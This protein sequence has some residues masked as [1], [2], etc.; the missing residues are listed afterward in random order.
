MATRPRSNSP[1]VSPDGRV[2]PGIYK[3]KSILTQTYVDIEVHLR[4]LCG[5]P[6]ENLGAGSGLVRT[7]RGVL[8]AYLTV[9]SGKSNLLDPGIPFGGYVKVYLRNIC[10][11]ILIERCEP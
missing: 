6:A 7:F 4:T 8:F 3:I 10:C 9:T 11:R 2:K 5:R 1:I